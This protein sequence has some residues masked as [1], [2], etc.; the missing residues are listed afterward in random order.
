ML[1]RFSEGTKKIV[2]NLKELKILIAGL[3]NAGKTSIL[4]VLDNNLEKIPLLKP[5]QGVEHNKYKVLGLDVIAWDLGGQVS[6]REKY[7]KEYRS[8]FSDAVVLFY[9]IDIQDDQ[10]FNESTKYLKDIVEAFTKMAMKDVYIIVLLHKYDA[11]IMIPTLLAKIST[12]KEKITKLLPKIASTFYETS[13]YEPYSIFQAISD[14]ILHQISGRELL[15]QKIKEIAESYNSL[16]AL[17]ISNKGYVYGAWHSKDV[18][19]TELAKFNKT[20]FDSARLFLEEEEQCKHLAGSDQ[21]DVAVIVFNYKEQIALFSLMVPKGADI[22]LI[23]K[24]LQKR[25]A[26][27][28]QILNLIGDAGK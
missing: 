8:Y 28:P 4:R 18:Q 9:V 13:I 1:L 23:K 20:T 3:S 16:A 26:E 27:F 11:H 15:H 5:T 22:Q 21:F 10:V 17:L 12:L 24:G 14:G 25:R 2:K 7:L 6:Y 19:V